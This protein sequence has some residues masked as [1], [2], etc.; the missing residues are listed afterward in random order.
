MKKFMMSNME[1]KRVHTKQNSMDYSSPSHPQ[2]S[3]QKMIFNELQKKVKESACVEPQLK[4]R[5]DKS[6]SHRLNTL[7]SE[8]KVG[9]QAAEKT[10]P[11]AQVC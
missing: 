10:K 11:F 8:I 3:L 9:I 4:R 1:K 5:N 7:P 6:I 2:K